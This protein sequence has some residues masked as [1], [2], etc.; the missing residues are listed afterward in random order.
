MEFALSSTY[1]RGQWQEGA[2]ELLPAQIPAGQAARNQG[3]NKD[4]GTTSYRK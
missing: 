1:S 2:Q 4:Y 3:K